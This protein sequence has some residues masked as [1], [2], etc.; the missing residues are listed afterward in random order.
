[1]AFNV[2]A[3]PQGILARALTDN[4]FVEMDLAFM[5]E[6]DRDG[7][8][9][10]KH[11][12]KNVLRARST[13]P[14][15]SVSNT[16][17]KQAF[18]R[19]LVV[20]ESFET[21]DP[22]DYHTHWREYQP[23]GDFQWEGLPAEVQATLEEL[24]LGT[25][26]EAVEDILTNGSADPA[27]TGL[28]PQLE[29]TSLTSLTSPAVAA[30]GTVTCA[31]A[32]ADDTVTVNGLV[33]TAVSGAKANNTQ[34]SIDT[35]DTAAAADLADSILNDARPGVTVPS[36]D[37]TAVSALGVV[38]IT[39]STLGVV[40]NGID[41]A[42]SNGT[43]LAVSAATLEDGVEASVTDATP[44]QVVNNTTIAFRAHGGGTGEAYGEILTTSNIFDKLELLIKRQTRAMRRRPGRKFMVSNAT[45]DLVMEAQ[46]LQLNFKGVDVTEEG[47]ARYAGY[48]II[49]NPSFPDNTILFCSMTGDMKTDAIQL[50]TSRSSDFNNLA[51]ARLNEF[52]RQWGMC[53][54]FALDIFVVRPEECCY[55][56]TNV[57][58]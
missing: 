37:V 14:S 11:D 48:D 12:I 52:N 9:A 15:A 33:Y 13:D 17:Q 27:I 53:L 2:G 31:S 45:R 29:S 18:K 51:V 35:S 49:A 39:A 55:Y 38:T 21:F 1:M 10:Y 46:R 19:N 25:S 26:A 41:L 47:I 8:N 42:S 58:A 24:F 23:E 30:S 28:I 34:F 36:V 6:G 5:N 20:V 54:T 43:R 40:G 44:T 7:Y 3:A 22:V 50:G 16:S 4:I 56:T 57:I 32:V